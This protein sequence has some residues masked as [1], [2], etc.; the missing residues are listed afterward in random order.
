MASHNLKNAL[1]HAGLTTEEFA[2]IVRVDPK[3][4]GRWVAGVSTP[5]PRHRQ[6]IARALD[7]PEHELWPE[8]SP[9]PPEDADRASS[10]AGDVTG[11]WGSSSDPTAPDV[12]SVVSEAAEQIEILDSDGTLLQ[13]PGLLDTLRQRTFDGCE[14]RVFT[15]TPP[16]ELTAL[17]GQTGFELR[18]ARG[19]STTTLVRADETILLTIPLAGSDPPAL[20]QLR[21]RD[22]DGVFDRL[23]AY[24]KILWD[25]AE[26]PA[27]PRQ[28]L[29]RQLSG[30]GVAD[31]PPGPPTR[32]THAAEEPSGSAPPT[33]EPA[34]RRWPRRPN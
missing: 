30:Y 19:S 18:I 26:I 8:K 10:T 27:Q 32:S 34:P 33:T 1:R 7:L 14:I 20:I 16:D 4:V 25:E 21:H 15:A 13:T 12:S 9:A 22:D 31:P 2:G 17:T 28:H 11:S 23:C 5:Y 29:A 24:F 3:T 6:T